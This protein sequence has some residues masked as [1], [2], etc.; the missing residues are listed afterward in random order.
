MIKKILKIN[1][2]V[3]KTKMTATNLDLK[4]ELIEEFIERA[5]VKK[6]LSYEEVI[7]F[8]D[9]NH[10]TEKETN[11]LLRVLEKKNINLVMQEELDD[12]LKGESFDTEELDAGK[13]QN[14]K[15][16]LS[17]IDEDMDEDQKEDDDED[18][19]ERALSHNAQITD[20][21]KCYLRDIGRIPLLNKKTEGVISEKISG[22]KTTSIEALSHFPV[23]HKEFVLI[24]DRLRKNTLQLKDIVQ[25]QEFDEENVPKI[26]AEQKALLEVID[27]I[28]DLID[29]EDKIYFSYRG[30]LTSSAKKQEMLNKVRDNKEEIAKTIRSIKLSNKLIR[31]LGKKIEKQV[32]KIQE[33]ESAVRFCREQLDAYAKRP[34]LSDTDQATMAELDRNLR[35]AQKNIKKIE[36]ELGLPLEK[37]NQFFTTLMVAQ[38]SDKLA[39]DDLARANLRLVVN[40]AKK[41][42][43]RGLHFLDLI[44]EGNIGLMKAVEKFEFERG[45][46]FSTYATWWIRQAITRAI[47]DQSRTIRVPVHMVETLNKINKI[48]RT[49]IQ[50]HGREP[51]HA[52]LAKELNLDENKIKNIIK[53]S[54][55]PISLETPVGD[56]D[57]AYIKDFIESENDFSPSDT[58]ASNDLKEKVR[59]ILKTLTPREEKVL[60]MRF[61][62][63]VASE[64]TLEEVG[65]DFSV[66]RE[67]IRQI[68]VKALRKLRHPSRSKKLRSFFDKEIEETLASDEPIE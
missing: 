13:L 65:K 29:N 35:I 42:V 1:K 57:D 37:T 9:K 33:K 53:I 8:G 61:G 51:S 30:K 10:L 54:K 24:A 49:F 27:H 5:R 21:V 59:E 39:K 2:I 3:D 50:E 44:Q 11:D 32:K 46:K 45:Y 26:D 41:Y 28:K 22:A 7:E 12:D 34:E 31:K 19:D 18:D 55:E 6:V 36:S 4:R 16:S 62:I 68:E 63:D 64:H 58:V 25:F 20:P 60:K 23:I 67:R 40:I 14:I 17:D 48:K 15:A 56:S 43:N 47:A 52:E 38:R 66:T